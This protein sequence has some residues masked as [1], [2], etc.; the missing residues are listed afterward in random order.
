MNVNSYVV[1]LRGINVGGKNKIPMP[2]LKR[3]LEELGFE[4]VATYI[5]SGNVLLR[6]DRVAQTIGPAI[7][8]MLSK[9]FKLDSDLIRVLV[10]SHDKLRA[11]VTRKP[12]GFGE[13]P[14]KYYSD[15]IFLM[16]I[17]AAQAMP[18]FKPREGVDE[19]W[20]GDGVIY[21]QRL[22]ALR[23]KSRLSAIVGTPA[24]KS[25]TIRNWNTTTKLLVLLEVMDTN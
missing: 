3:C 12:K 25:M 24:Y 11:I 23:T 9:K 13:Q 18:V 1:L 5:Q 19:V 22:G 10:L 16:G 4:D 21:S 7:E 15:A 6:S 17:E 2:E 8:T 20:P 14:E